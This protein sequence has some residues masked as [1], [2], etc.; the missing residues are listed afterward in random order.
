LEAELLLSH[1]TGLQRV[2]FFSHPERALTSKQIVELTALLNRRLDGEPIAYI[3]GSKEFWSLALSIEPGVLV[4]RPDTEL[5]VEKALSLY[6]Q[7]P[8]GFIVELGTGSGAIALALAQEIDDQTLF[9]I[10]RNTQALHIAARNIKSFGLN[11]V[12]LIQASW[13]DALQSQSAA[14]IISNPPYLAA[15]DE[16]LP[17]LKHEPHNALVSGTTGMED[18]EAI[19]KESRRVCIPG[20]VLLLEHGYHQG[21][22]VRFLLSSYNYHYVKTDR[23]L[24]GHERVSYGY[25]MTSSSE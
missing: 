5:L 17:S 25:L 22:D 10:E 20:G 11:R 24:A 16:H 19:I 7:L 3:T 6:P 4:P 14:M 9:A 23:D 2:S 1:V 21:H 12:Q 15:D 18:L 13:L 8:T